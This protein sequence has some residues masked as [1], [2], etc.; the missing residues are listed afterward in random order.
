MRV[1]RYLERLAPLDEALR[2]LMSA[3]RRV[4]GVE[5]LPTLEAVGRVA[6][7]DVVASHD[8]PPRPRAAYDGYAVRSEDTPGKLRLVGEATIGRVDVGVKVDPGTAVYVST[9]AYLP[10]GADAVV[11]EEAVRVEG[12]YIVVETRFERWKNVDPPGSYVRRGQKLLEQGTVVTMLDAVGLMDVAVTSLRVYEPVSV[13]ILITGSE[14]FEPGNPRADEERILR[15]EVAETTGKLIEWCINRYTPWARVTARLILPDDVDTIAW[16]VERQLYANHLIVMTGGTGPS[17]VDTFYQLAS[18]LRGEVLFRGIRVRGGRPTSAMKLE[19][20]PLLVAV[21]GH[22]ISALHGFLRLLYPL[23]RYMG[24]VRR[25]HER[26]AALAAR[27]ATGYRAARPEPLKVRLV[28]RE[29]GVVLAEPLPRQRQLSSVIVSNVEAD[30]IA[31]VD[32]REYS[33][34]DVVRVMAY[35]E[36][37]PAS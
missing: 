8:F 19:D 37:R 29:D 9:G 23:L 26:P 14:L 32:A 36:P 6:A 13:A 22:P 4:E 17:S 34:G 25:A 16:Y 2:R 33:E 20:G 28:E 30:G 7:E 10:E 35:R 24:N 15:G 5:E 27:L 21:S 31:L 11:P 3:A 18:K 1:S 12:D